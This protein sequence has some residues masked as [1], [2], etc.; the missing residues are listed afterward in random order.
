[1][2][3][4]FPH[5]RNFHS[6]FEIFILGLKFSFS[7][8]NYQS[9]ALFF[10]AAREGPR[11][12]ISFSIENFIQ[13]W[14]LDF[15]FQYR[16]SRFNVFQSWGPLGGY[17]TVM[18]RYMLQNGVSHTCACAWKTKYQGG[19]SH[20]FGELLTSLKR[21]RKIWGIAA[22]V[23]RRRRND[24]NSLLQSFSDSY[25]PLVRPPGGWKRGNC[26]KLFSLYFLGQKRRR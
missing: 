4:P 1:M 18:A 26:P 2:K 7:I 16:L 9:Q 15:F 12:K 5:A 25:G 13:Y 3:K 24:K 11:M 23:S 22:I 19:L 14:K 8:E 10:S 20:Q 6:R 21:Y 17:R